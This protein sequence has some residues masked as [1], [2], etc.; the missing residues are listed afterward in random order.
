MSDPA[1]DFAKHPGPAWHD[2]NLPWKQFQRLA[3]SGT[4]RA[5]DQ[6]AIEALGI[7]GLILMENAARSV[8]DLVEAEI[9]RERPEA[10]VVVCCGRGNNGGDGF[11]V[12]RL[13]VNRGFHVSVIDAGEAKTDDARTNQHLWSHFG[14]SVSFPSPEAIRWLERADVILDAIFGIGLERKIEGA[15]HEWIE[16]INAN[17]RALRVALD[18]P[19]G[20]NSDDSRL[21]GVAVR[22]H[23]TVCFQIGKP[24]CFQQPGAEF[25]G[26]ITIPDISIP[27]HWSEQGPRIW[28]LTRQAISSL[29]PDV[30]DD[31][32][33]GYFGHLLTVCG[34][35]GMGGAATL[36]ATAALKSGTGLVSAFVPERFRDGLPSQPPE[37]MTLSSPGSP[38]FLTPEHTDAALS[39]AISRNAVVLGCGL[40]NHSETG[41]FVRTFVMKT[42]A[43]L[44][45]DADGLNHLSGQDLVECSGPTVI[46]PHPKELSRLCGQSVAEIQASRIAT[47]RRWAQAWGVVLVL[48]GSRTVVAAPDGAVFLNPTG[49]AG[50]ATAGSGDVLSG[51]IGGLL[52]QGCSPLA[53]ALVGVYLHGLAAD[54]LVQEGLPP[55]ALTASDLFRGIGLAQNELLRTAV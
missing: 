47:T 51:M 34:S 44:L 48:K 42:E 31:S 38:D 13:L 8:A 39:H 12:A 21:H 6:H 5:M 16:T 41:E 3:D 22:C 14:E 52:A 37:V 36:A 10:R 23:H 53:A 32:H 15:H 2:P 24:G 9:L 25:C 20:I 28:Q 1:D 27:P 43:P 45:V 7:P 40:G 33:K 29:L 19:S 4:M 54:Q 18:V 50:L 55:T 35:A 49:N 26:K 17:S 46:T 11:A 30:P